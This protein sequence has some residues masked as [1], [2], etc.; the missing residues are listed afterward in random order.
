MKEWIDGC[1]DGWVERQSVD[2]WMEKETNYSE[3]MKKTIKSE[4]RRK[5]GK[6]ND[7][8]ETTMSGERETR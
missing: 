1:L 3:R 4:Y 6:W 5:D 7:G 2:G 8:D